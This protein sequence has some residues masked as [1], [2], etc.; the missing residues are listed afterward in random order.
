MNL[1]MHTIKDSGIK[2][3]RLTVVECSN[4][5][6]LHI[7]KRKWCLKQFYCFYICNIPTTFFQVRRFYSA[8]CYYLFI[9]KV[10]SNR[11]NSLI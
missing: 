6:I 7:Y 2:A 11:Y 4:V 9:Y 3:F 5:T 1:W 10:S 8:A